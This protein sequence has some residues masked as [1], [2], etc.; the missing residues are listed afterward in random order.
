MLDG[1]VLSLQQQLGN[2]FILYSI[3]QTKSSSDV[4]PIKVLGW[5]PERQKSFCIF[6]NLISNIAE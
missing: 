6:V 5:S 1:L 2:M 4:K 3:I